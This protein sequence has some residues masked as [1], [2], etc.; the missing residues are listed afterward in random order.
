L[1]FLESSSHQL[2]YRNPAL[3]PFYFLGFLFLAVAVSLHFRN[4][5][6]LLNSVCLSVC[7][8]CTVR[9]LQS[10]FLRKL[11]G[12]T[13][14]VNYIESPSSSSSCAEFEV[15]IGCCWFLVVGNLSKTHRRKEGRI[16]DKFF[17]MKSQIVGHQNCVIVATYLSLKLSKSEK[18]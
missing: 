11:R 17:C 15:E 10:H 14:L 13:G 1:Q 12:Q 7:R 4:Q 16:D 2:L 9:I 6:T 5:V 8:N 18:G 3:R